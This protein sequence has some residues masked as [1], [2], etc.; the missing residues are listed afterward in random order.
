MPNA[1]LALAL[2]ATTA[3]GTADAPSVHSAPAKE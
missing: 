3:S 1:L 2:T